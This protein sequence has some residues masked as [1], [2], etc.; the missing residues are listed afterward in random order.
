[1][2]HPGCVHGTPQHR[3]Y[4]DV[5]RLFILERWECCKDLD[6]RTFSEIVRV[7]YGTLR[8][9]MRGGRQDIENLTAPELASQASDRAKGVRTESI[10][11]A[12]KT[13]KGSFPDFCN[14]VQLHLHIPWG[15]TAI[16][17]IL[18]VYGVRKRRPREAA[19]QTTT[20]LGASST[21]SSAEPCGRPTARRATSPSMA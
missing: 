10:L 18:H 9:W 12:Y 6:L 1:M 2:D 16:G 5:F 21:P 20:R 15:R 4:A 3:R 7:P 14:H 13:W 11:A 17:E 8:D 19:A